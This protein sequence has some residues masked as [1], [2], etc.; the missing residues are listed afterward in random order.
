[1]IHPHRKYSREESRAF[2]E[3]MELQPA[4]PGPLSGLRFAVKDVID[5]GGYRTSY[6]NPDWAKTHPQAAANAV[7]VD[8]LL[9][10]GAQCVGKTVTDELAFSLD[11]E[12]FFYGT[13]LNP[14]APDRVPGGS[15]SG[16]ASAVAC[17]LV[18]FSLGNDTGGS[19]RVPAA[20]CGIFGLRPSPGFISTAGVHPFSPSLDTVGVLAGSA[21]I[22]SRAASVLLAVPVPAKAEVGRLHLIT[23]AWE[24]ADAEVREA[25]AGAVQLIRN[26]FASQ[27]CETSI[28]E[29]DGE[30]GLGLKNWYEP[31]STIQWAEIWSCFGSWMESAKPTLS[32]RTRIN[33]ELAKNAD[34]RPVGE[35][36]RAR[37]QYFRGL[38]SFMAP[39]DLLCIP[40]VPAVA[41][42]K[43]KPG[44]DRSGQSKRRYYPRTLSI[45]AIAGLGR[46]P[47]VSLP[48]GEVGGVPVGLSILA[49]HGQDAY[50]LGVV[51]MVAGQAGLSS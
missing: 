15:S 22:L 39:H 33:F 17:G 48:L 13:P 43:G 44:E 40:T 35:A 49:A 31:Y 24:L 32:P 3:T 4:A 14:K 29:I 51:E 5:L 37:E 47:E 16:S 41:R 28:H 30:A 23:E 2:I 38:A 50:L 18:D 1:M 10:A 20:N 25:L 21:E 9:G 6:G 8:Q 42:L 19:V 46:L 26:R 36:I 45:T 11:G 27:V 12:N 34:R 7:C